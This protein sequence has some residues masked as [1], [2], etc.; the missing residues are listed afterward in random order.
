M[1]SY[2][3]PSEFRQL[4]LTGQQ[5][6]KDIEEHLDGFPYNEDRPVE[7]Q[8]SEEL[9]DLI[10]QLWDRCHRWFNEL[11]IQVLPRTT[12]DRSY[13]NL[14]LRRLT[15]TIRSFKFYEEYRSPWFSIH[16]EDMG[17][18][19]R[20]VEYPV[21]L[22]AAKE[23]VRDVIDQS[24]RL[25]RTATT[26]VIS[27]PI[28]AKT[29]GHIANTAFILI[30]MDTNHPELE[31]V[32]QAVKEVFADFGIKALRADKIQHQDRITDLILNQ[33]AQRADLSP[34]R[35]SEAKQKTLSRRFHVS[36]RQ[37]GGAI[38]DIAICDLKEGS[39]WTSHIAICLHRAGS[40]DALQRSE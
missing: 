40:G 30:W 11:T 38:F 3:P 35:S 5:L 8:F 17:N 14:L 1:D 31:D 21:S 15:T 2:K 12:F 37:E 16:Q 36:I 29:S 10:E 19:Q 6:R 32:Y 13:T 28:A 18:V 7:G 25:I 23:E 4:Y 33:I 9:T 39:R 24:L 20:N 26:E 27:Q 22:P 34:E